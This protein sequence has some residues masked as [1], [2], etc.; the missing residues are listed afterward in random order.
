MDENEKTEDI[1]LK[2][3]ELI[4]T[5]CDDPKPSPNSAPNLESKKSSWLDL[6]LQN[7]SIVSLRSGFHFG[8]T[9][10]RFCSEYSPKAS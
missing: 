6:S 8:I 4:V 10:F 1:E 3:I 9:L 7:Q 2:N 5:E